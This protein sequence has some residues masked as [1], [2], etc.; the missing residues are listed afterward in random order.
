MSGTMLVAVD[1]SP[2]GYNA[3]IWVLEHIKEEGRACALYVI[4]P[5][6]YAAIDGAA[7]YEGISTLH[8]IRERIVQDEKEQVI[9]R[10]K[11]LAH[12]RGVD[13]EVIVRTGDPRN[14]ILTAADEIGADLIAV[15]STGKGLGARILLG[16]VSTYILSHAKVSTI[17][18]R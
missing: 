10:V 6:K 4:S 2:E 5:S 11:E 15:G 1:G 13:V 16:S 18:V 12:D 17:V 7:G 3:L 9:S 8:E 14:E